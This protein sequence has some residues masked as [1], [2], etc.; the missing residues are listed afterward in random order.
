MHRRDKVMISHCG[1]RIAPCP[2]QAYIS[3]LTES[4]MR[5]N[6]ACV[7]SVVLSQLR[8]QCNCGRHVAILTASRSSCLTAVSNYIMQGIMWSPLHICKMVALRNLNFVASP[9]VVVTH[10]AWNHPK[11]NNNLELFLYCKLL[12]SCAFTRT[13][14]QWLKTGSLWKIRESHFEI[15]YLFY[16]FEIRADTHTRKKNIRTTISKIT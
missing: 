4:E 2:K 9:K 14:K 6:V 13:T 11:N 1:L 12:L 15:S 8:L 10:V 7:S 5:R 16:G 3:V